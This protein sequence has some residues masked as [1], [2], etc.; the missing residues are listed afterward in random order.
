MRKLRFERRGR[1]RIAPWRVS[2]LVLLLAAFLIGISSASLLYVGHVA[3]QAANFQSSENDLKL[4]GNALRDRQNLM[5]R[6]Q[7]GL[8][9]WDK[10]FAN[11]Q[12]KFSR[13]FLEDEVV[14]TLW[15]DFAHDEI[16]LVGPDKVLRMFA[17]Q[18]ETAFP[19]RALA[20]S[21]L[22]YKIADRA[23]LRFMRNRIASQNG[24]RQKAVPLGQAS[25]VAEF[26]FGRFD[27]KPA[28]VSA[29]A[30]VPDDDSSL[31]M[32]DGPPYIL[33]SARYIEGA[34][35]KELNAQLGF[36]AFAF[37]DERASATQ[38]RRPIFD[39]DGVRIGAFDWTGGSPGE[40][41]WRVVIPIIVLLALALALAA[42]LLARRIGAI[43]TRLEESEAQNRQLALHDPLT[44]LA[45]RL[46]FARALDDAIRALDDRPFALLACDLDRFKAVN[47]TYGHAGGDTVIRTVAMRLRDCVGDAGLV[48][49]T[50]GDE[51]VI[52][53]TAWADIPRLTI[54]SQRMIAGICEPITLD[55]GSITDVGTSLGI[56]LSPG[57]G[58]TAEGIMAA[59]DAALYMAKERGRGIAVFAKDI[60][61]LDE[62]S[63]STKNSS[64]AQSH[65]A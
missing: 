35:E 46:K 45:N 58:E 47:D 39:L 59:A 48:S 52:L 5:A 14:D 37:R 4:F 26:A 27:G 54:L 62:P 21:E 28:V 42:L 33:V 24:F 6:D 8:A 9:R 19:D 2:T 60:A 57:N 50:G 25:D 40:H 53:V 38:G 29:M 43:S 36:A 49:R 13:S 31:V 30:I 65:A 56:A 32:P 41:I 51:F 23:V 61:R 12:Q 1:P 55:D 18:G 16:V 3:S 44:G 20:E 17:R 11:I 10:G 22:L 15:S 34:F 64:G 63:A 7:L